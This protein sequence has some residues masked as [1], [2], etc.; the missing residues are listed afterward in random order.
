MA[1][2]DVFPSKGMASKNADD[3]GFRLGPP[4]RTLE[5]MANVVKAKNVGPMLGAAWREPA[6]GAGC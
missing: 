2:G 3:L 4:W 5:A 6:D 1:D